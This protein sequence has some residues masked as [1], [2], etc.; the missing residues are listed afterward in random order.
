M[1]RL[2]VLIAFTAVSVVPLACIE[3]QDKNANHSEDSIVSSGLM[4]K[5]VMYYYT[6]Q[7]S[8]GSEIKDILFTGDELKH[9]I[10]A[11]IIDAPKVKYERSSACQASPGKHAFLEIKLKL[12]RS[13]RS[14]ETLASP[15]LGCGE[16]SAPDLTGVLPPEFLGDILEI[17]QPKNIGSSLTY[18]QNNLAV[19]Q[20]RERVEH[21][22]LASNPTKLSR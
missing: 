7:S 14:S 16:G 9:P 5:S 8:C 3:K 12:S 19:Y 11:S 21:A 17:L 20:Y 6:S 22:D 15:F 2:H 13:D 1:G 18:Q 10:F 4:L